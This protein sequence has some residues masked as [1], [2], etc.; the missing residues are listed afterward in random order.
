MS[1][2]LVQHFI[3]EST[4]YNCY[5]DTGSNSGVVNITG[6]TPLSDVPFPFTGYDIEPGTLILDF[7]SD[8]P[9]T[10]QV[11]AFLQT[12]T[13]FLNFTLTPN[14]PSCP[15]IP[16]DT[17]DLTI[18]SLTIVNEQSTG[19]NDGSVTIN[20]A[21]SNGPIQYSLDGSTWQDSN[22]FTGLAPGNY[23]AFTKDASDCDFSQI[24]SILAYNNPVQNFGD[25]LPVVTVGPANI[26]KWNA[27]FNPIVVKFQ[28]KDFNVLTV[29]RLNATQIL[30]ELDTILTFAQYTL[31]ISDV[32]YFK[33]ASY[34]FL[35]KADAHTTSGGH[36][37]LTITEPYT[38]DDTVGYLNINNIKP[39]YYVEC[40]I[41]Y[42]IDPVHPKFINPLYSPSMKGATRADLAPFLKTLLD[43]K[44]TYNYTDASFSDT[45]ISQ[46]YQLSY[47]EVWTGGNGQWFDS[48]Y[49]LYVVRAAMQLGEPNNGNM[50][51]YVPFQAVTN[52]ADKALFLTNFKQPIYWQGL[53]FEIS[54]I[55]SEDLIDKAL[56][57]ELT[58]DCGGA[59][60]G[61]LLNADAGHVLDTDTGR[62]I[63]ARSNISGI[64]VLAAL[65]VNRVLIPDSFDCCA[66]Q[67][68]VNIY[69][70]QDSVKVYVMQ[71]MIIRTECPCDEP[72]AY[73]KWVNS[74][75]GWDYYRFGF[76]QFLNADISND[77]AVKRF[78]ENWSKDDTIEEII[79]KSSIPSLKVGANNVPKDDADALQW[80][81]KSIKVMML[82]NTNP[83]RWESVIIKDGSTD[84]IQT[85]KKRSDVNFELLLHSD[86]IQTQ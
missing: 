55:Y 4:S 47:R 74:Y 6:P 5:Y 61:F 41:K 1:L 3:Y 26:S 23:T 60:D 43:F 83:V 8:N 42:G 30:V 27:A 29:T 18:T 49:P 86:N 33:T 24:F 69:Y 39:G 19:A 40:R 38:V 34:E 85:R 16:P 67:I 84:T 53:P 48:P 54:F 80:A 56:A 2:I 15:V 82:V 77:Q 17:C 22:V 12:H 7:C 11:H 25:D 44:D 10:T 63:I 65:G 14:S 52:P 21:T 76:N 20:A 75:G 68:K 32:M 78:V 28:R 64:D 70:L 59:V 31:A 71:D 79:N 37:I 36:S 45:S 46:S 72:Y 62:F 73:I 35:G 51:K 9:N 58:P 50:A 13:P 81:R 66:T 57:V